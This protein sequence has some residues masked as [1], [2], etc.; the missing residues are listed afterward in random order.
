M[1]SWSFTVSFITCSAPSDLLISS[2]PSR[3][4][5]ILSVRRRSEDKVGPA[6]GLDASYET[7]SWRGPCLCSWDIVLSFS[8]FGILWSY[9]SIGTGLA[10]VLCP[11][12]VP[13]ALIRGAG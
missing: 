4:W 13:S 9:L 11:V 3:I 6:V 1:L 5:D 10:M 12:S 2:I 8:Q 7:S